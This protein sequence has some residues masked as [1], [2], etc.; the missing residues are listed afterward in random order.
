MK[1]NIDESGKIIY[2]IPEVSEF[3]EIIKKSNEEKKKNHDFGLKMWSEHLK[4]RILEKLNLSLYNIESNKNSIK[5]TIPGWYNDEHIDIVRKDFQKR[6][7]K[8]I[9]ISHNEKKKPFFYSDV[10]IKK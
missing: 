6:G 5:F 3:D 9:Q 7:W 4:D 8:D 1:Y 10:T 2:E